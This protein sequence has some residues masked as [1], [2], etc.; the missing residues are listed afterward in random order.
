[1]SEFFGRVG[2]LHFHEDEPCGS[3]PGMKIHRGHRKL[4]KHDD[5]PGEAHELTFSCYRRLQLLRFDSRCELLA[6]SVDAAMSRH[7]YELLAYAFM[8]E[9]VHLL[10]L[11]AE[12]LGDK[13]PVAPLP[14]RREALADELPVAPVPDIREALGDKHPVAP[15]G[16]S[17]LLYAIKKPFSFRIKQ[18]M[19]ADGDPMLD[20]LTIRDRP[21]STSFR[22]WQEGPGYDRNIRKKS[23]M[24]L[25]IDYIHLNPVRR[26]LVDHPSKWPWSSW[27]HYEEE[28]LE[29]APTPPRIAVWI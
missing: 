20:V 4:V 22:F 3:I 28:D 2:I 24:R 9:H 23:T 14:D 1:L 15:G 16:I 26:G 10:V 17:K 25:V 27:R 12:A 21:G 11:P 13:H 6:E 5:A 18:T 29:N 19:A 8:P 7:G